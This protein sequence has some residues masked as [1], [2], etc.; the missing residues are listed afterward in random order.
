VSKAKLAMIAPSFFVMGMETA[1][2]DLA[3]DK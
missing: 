2:M 1:M 3:K